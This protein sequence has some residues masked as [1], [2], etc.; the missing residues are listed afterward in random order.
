MDFEIV[1]GD[2][3]PTMQVVESPA[4]LAAQQQQEEDPF[5]P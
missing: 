4:V 1:R 2:L 3:P 5:L